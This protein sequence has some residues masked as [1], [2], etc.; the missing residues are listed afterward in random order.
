MAYNYIGCRKK[1]IYCSEGIL[2]LFFI[3][4]VTTE[5]ELQ[6]VRKFRKKLEFKKAGSHELNGHL[7][8][9]F[10]DL[11]L[12]GDLGLV[13]KLEWCQWNNC[14]W[15]KRLATHSSYLSFT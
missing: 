1:R 6:N 9:V 4:N 12:V 5:K 8:T 7:T 14:R 2:C 11:T 15:W 3:C 10:Y 13:Y